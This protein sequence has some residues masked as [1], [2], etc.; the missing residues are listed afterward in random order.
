MKRLTPIDLTFLLPALHS[1]P[2]VPP[3]CS[4]GKRKAGTARK[5]S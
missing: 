4:P 5:R 2:I 1:L 3:K